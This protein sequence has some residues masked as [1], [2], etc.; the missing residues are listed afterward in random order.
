[1]TLRS[2]RVTIFVLEKEQ[3]LNT[4]RTVCI[5]ALLIRHA[6]RMRRIMLP[7]VACLALPYIPTL[8]HKRQDF[9]KKVI[10]HKMCVSI[11]STKFVRNTSHSKKKRDITINGQSSRKVPFIF[12]RF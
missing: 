1:M 4:L 12:V 8:S 11:F 5:L 9:R 2:V 10:G 7:S 3:V 6:T